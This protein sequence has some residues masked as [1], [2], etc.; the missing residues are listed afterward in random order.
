MEY[1]ELRKI[2][3]FRDKKSSNLLV[4]GRN[5][6]AYHVSAKS[7]S[8]RTLVGKCPYFQV[9]ESA[10]MQRSVNGVSQAHTGPTI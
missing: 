1:L 5:S 8:M 7:F 2:Y 6:L 4:N 10:K 9:G 3:D